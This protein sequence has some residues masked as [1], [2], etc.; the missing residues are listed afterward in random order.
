MKLLFFELA[1]EKE[2]EDY[3]KDKIETIIVP[4][5][6]SALKELGTLRCKL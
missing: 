3:D 6:A 5:Y 4:Y 1:T 2:G